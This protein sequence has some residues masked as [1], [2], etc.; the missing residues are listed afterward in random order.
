M[1]FF[2]KSSICQMRSCQKKGIFQVTV[3]LL[4]GIC[5]PE[6][7]RSVTTGSETPDFSIAER[8]KMNPDRGVPWNYYTAAGIAWQWTPSSLPETNSN[9]PLQKMMYHVCSFTQYTTYTS[10][11]HHTAQ[12]CEGSYVGV[13][14]ITGRV[15]KK[16]MLTEKNVREKTKSHDCIHYT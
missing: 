3:M 5:S 13:G 8:Q 10:C 15:G 4:H 11:T 6:M 2:H 16:L 14:D 12:V 1:I 9:V 7:K